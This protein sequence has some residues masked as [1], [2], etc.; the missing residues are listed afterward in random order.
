[1]EHEFLGHIICGLSDNSDTTLNATKPGKAAEYANTF[2]VEMG[3][4]VRFNYS[5]H[6]N[7]KDEAR[8]LF[9]SKDKMIYEVVVRNI[10]DM[11]FPRLHLKIT[12]FIGDLTE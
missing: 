1:M 11:A 7:E 8:L 6:D 2:S 3:I 4:P 12:T 9:I 5:V 10:S